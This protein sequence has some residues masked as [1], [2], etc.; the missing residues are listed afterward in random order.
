MSRITKAVAAIIFMVF[1]ATL[2]AQD[3]DLIQYNAKTQHEFKE[4]DEQYFAQFEAKVGDV[5]Y[6]TVDYD[7]FVIGTL[8]IDIRDRV[9][10]SIGKKVD[11][12]L[13]EYIIAEVKDAGLYTVVIKA[14]EPGVVN[15]TLGET[16][17]INDGW[18]LKINKEDKP[19]PFLINVAQA[20]EYIVVYQKSSGDLDVNFTIIDY[21][22][23]FS[24]TVA[25]VSGLGMSR[26]AI[27]LNLETNGDYVVFIGE[28]FLS[29]GSGDSASVN[30]TFKLAD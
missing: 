16:G 14:E 1:T 22:P 30:L 11:F 9:G 19:R 12:N 17:Y 25:D 27:I 21:A 28:E 18:T 26:W 6:L 5:V 15:V 13:Q 10:R 23:L 2:M 4:A 20:D 8:E 3:V 7:D 24:E 29:F